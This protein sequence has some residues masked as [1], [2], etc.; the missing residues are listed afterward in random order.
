M[1]IDIKQEFKTFT[2]EEIFEALKQN[3]LEHIR[4]DWISV[5]DGKVVGACA[6]GQAAYNLNV[7]AYEE[8]VDIFGAY[9]NANGNIYDAL[10]DFGLGKGSPWFDEDFMAEDFS[11]ADT[12]IFWNDRK[13]SAGTY[14]LKT[15]AEVVNMAR[16]VLEPYF[17]ETVELPHYEY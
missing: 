12:I 6:L 8:Q 1:I 7:P 14:T 10:N 9:I 16:E 13:S 11:V 5:K 4:Q 17:K 2:V 3:G 15:Y